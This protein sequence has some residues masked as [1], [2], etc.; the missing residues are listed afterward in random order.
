MSMI[1]DA[2]AVL[3][4]VGAHHREAA[5]VGMADVDRAEQPSRSRSGWPTSSGRPPGTFLSAREW[6]RWEGR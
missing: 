3:E 2:L 4:H 6:K 1:S 5:Q